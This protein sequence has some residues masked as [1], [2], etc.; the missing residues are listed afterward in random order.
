MS[1]S[2]V[3]AIDQGTTSTRAILFD[4]A[5]SYADDLGFAA[6]PD[7]YIVDADGTIRWAIYGE[8]SEAEVTGLLDEVLAEQAAATGA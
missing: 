1:K 4:E 8:T 7:T 5:G 3:L 6:L 2:Y